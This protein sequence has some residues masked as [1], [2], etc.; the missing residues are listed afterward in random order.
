MKFI[1]VMELAEDALNIMHVEKVSQYVR[2]PED[3]QRK[4]DSIP[5]FELFIILMDCTLNRR[6]AE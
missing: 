6:S 4:S 5:T 2:M 1:S 3:H